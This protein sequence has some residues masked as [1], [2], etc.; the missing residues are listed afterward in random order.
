M[1]MEKS[2]LFMSNEVVIYGIWLLWKEPNE[3]YVASE[4]QG[5]WENALYSWLW[6][7]AKKDHPNF[8]G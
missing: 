2:V 4:L 7:M 8:L 3:E 5:I 1:E 6:A